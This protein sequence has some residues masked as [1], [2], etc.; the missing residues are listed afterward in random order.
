MHGQQELILLWKY[1]KMNKAT[2]NWA[3]LLIYLFLI[4]YFSSL[5]KI[6]VLE[7]APEFYLRDK[8]LHVV[9]YGFLGFLS[10]NAFK[11]NKFLNKK[12]FFYAVMFATIY[13]I[14]DEIHQLFIPN[15]IFSLI[16]ITAD[17][18]G[19]SLILFKKLIK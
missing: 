18:L 12:I 13:G 8:V 17:F 14:T 15:R 19:S 6:E 3:I 2:F 5:P 11:H 10:Y 7:K 16:D 1:I 9:E 4:F